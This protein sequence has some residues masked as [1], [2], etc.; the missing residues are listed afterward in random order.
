MNCQL[1]VEK[2]LLFPR[3]VHA[4]EHIVFCIIFSQTNRHRPTLTHLDQVLVCDPLFVFAQTSWLRLHLNALV[5]R[6]FATAV[7]GTR[8]CTSS[9]LRSHPLW[10]NPALAPLRFYVQLVISVGNQTTRYLCLH[11]SGFTFSSVDLRLQLGALT[12]R[13]HIR[14]CL[15]SRLALHSSSRLWSWSRWN[16]HSCDIVPIVHDSYGLGRIYA[17]SKTRN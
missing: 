3:P 1:R 6:C 10:Y 16:L 13:Q 12:L 2:A 7:E 17:K 5:E 9:R 14:L 8:R 4:E 11:P 15:W